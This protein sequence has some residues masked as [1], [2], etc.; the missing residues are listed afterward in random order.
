[1]DEEDALQQIDR[2]EY[3]KRILEVQLND[4]RANYSHFILFVNVLQRA[5]EIASIMTLL[6]EYGDDPEDGFGMCIFCIYFG[7]QISKGCVTTLKI[8]NENNDMEE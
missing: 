1:V 6:K 2:I 4:V 5:C 8:Y 3:E 7:I